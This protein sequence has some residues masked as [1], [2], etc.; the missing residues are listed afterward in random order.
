MNNFVYKN[1]KNRLTC[2]FFHDIVI[3][4]FKMQ[5]EYNFVDQLVLLKFSTCQNQLLVQWWIGIIWEWSE[6]Y[7]TVN[8]QIWIN[9]RDFLVNQCQGL[10]STLDSRTWSTMFCN[11]IIIWTFTTQGEFK[12]VNQPFLLIISTY[13]LRHLV[14][15]WTP[16]TWE[17]PCT[18]NTVN[19]IWLFEIV[20]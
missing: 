17:G 1:V 9:C 13:R 15:W 14:Q 2:H 8:D 6:P 10:T 12:L 5:G 20:K 19:Q 16:I 18:Y 7:N 3:W 4:T 11:V